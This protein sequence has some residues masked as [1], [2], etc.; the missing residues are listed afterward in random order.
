MCQQDCDTK[1]SQKLIPICSS[2][3]PNISTKTASVSLKEIEELCELQVLVI[4]QHKDRWSP[5]KIWQTIVCGWHSNIPICCIAFFLLVWIPL[6]NFRDF[7]WVRKITHWW[8]PISFNYVPCPFCFLFNRRRKLKK[9]EI[10][11]GS[12][13]RFQTHN[14]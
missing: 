6:F 1:C 12:C 3:V 9:C 5:T 4:N 7:S 8:P 10:T 14:S 2:S 11:C 13:C